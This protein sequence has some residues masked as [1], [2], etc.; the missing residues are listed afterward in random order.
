M[1]EPNIQIAAGI[2]T[3]DAATAPK[4]VIFQDPCVPSNGPLVM[5]VFQLRL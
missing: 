5:S 1:A 4:P 3:G 2:G